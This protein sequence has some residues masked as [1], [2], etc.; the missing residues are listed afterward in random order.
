MLF[1]GASSGLLNRMQV[2]GVLVAGDQ[3]C[4]LIPAP[5]DFLSWA[6]ASLASHY[7]TLIAFQ[8]RVLWIPT[9]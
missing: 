9:K 5:D 1:C 8:N 7:P 2:V 6:P 3:N 4:P